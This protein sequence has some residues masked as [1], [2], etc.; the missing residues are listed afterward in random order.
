MQKPASK[1]LQAA[2]FATGFSG[3]VA[4]Y[5]LATLASY[6]LGDSIVQ[7][8]LTISLMLFAMGLGSRFTK[9]VKSNEFIWFIGIEITLSIIVSF[10][11]LIIYSIAPYTSY[12][13]L[14]IYLLSFITGLLIGMEL[15]LAIR[16]NQVYE[17][18]EINV[19]Q[20]LE[21]DYYGSLLGG[22]FFSFIGL[23]YLGLSYTPFVLGGVNLA[24]AT[25]LVLIYHKHAIKQKSK[26]PSIAIVLSF[27]VIAIGLSHAQE[28]IELSEQKNY[29]DKVVYSEQSK[30]QQITITQWKD[31]YWLYL[32][33]NLQL[34]T[35]D[36]A[37]YHEVLVHPA[38][39]LTPHTRKVLL[40][41]GG[42]GCAAREL[43]KYSSIESITL[44]DLDPAV[45][46][47]AKSNLLLT[48]INDHSLSDDRVSVIN[49]DGYHFMDTTHA[50]F[51]L[52]IIDLPDPRN[53][54]LSRLYSKEMYSI[55][56][57]QLGEQGVLI[58][59]AGSPY[60]AHEA[61]YCIAKTIQSA[62][63]SAIPMHNQIVTMGEWGWVLASKHLPSDHMLSILQNGEPEVPTKW[64]N[65]NALIQVTSFGK[66]YFR[67]KRDSIETNTFKNPILY[68]YYLN[69][70]WEMY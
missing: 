57:K 30:Y 26:S 51:D 22:I 1:A 29:K 15:P 3:V 12:L 25:L 32:N 65:N 68:R 28:I 11:A 43:L 69:G 56:H 39:L 14:F 21:K 66:P 20:I 53:V 36:E 42:D 49:G 40:L 7:W 46:E 18:I 47:L 41:G 37:L 44:V 23:P 8:A 33:G 67:N 59:Q 9:Q 60:F 35:Y 58:T 48:Q 34:S 4:E 5:V 50:I 10:S 2:L 52:I 13:G 63:F 70:A 54:E 27:V 16:L 62:G 38:M 17:R 55:C 64:L 31:D 19:S 45:T 24:V 6:F 61:F